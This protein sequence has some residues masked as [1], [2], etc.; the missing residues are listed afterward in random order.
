MGLHKKLWG[1]ELL[2]KLEG[3]ALKALGNETFTSDADGNTDYAAVTRRL[4][5]RFGT[6]RGEAEAKNRLQQFAQTKKENFSDYF[7]RVEET[8]DQAHAQNPLTRA[9][10]DEACIN[11]ARKGLHDKELRAAMQMQRAATFEAWCS[12]CCSLDTYR[13]ADG[14]KAPPPVDDGSKKGK[15]KDKKN[16]SVMHVQ[17]DSDDDS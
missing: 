2:D 14:D 10:H 4:S 3:R 12:I 7:G 8:V 1:D 13:W 16:S 15:G 17:G 6:V 5:A 9:Q 11:A